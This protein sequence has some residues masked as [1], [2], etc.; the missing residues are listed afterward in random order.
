M[1]ISLASL[2]SGRDTRPPRVLVHGVSG[3]GKTTLA[4]AADKPVFLQTE[5]GLGVLDAQTFGLLK[6]FDQVMEGLGSLYTEDHDFK[7]LVVDSVDWLEP[8]VWAKVC[9][10][11]NWSSIEQPGYGKGYIEAVNVWREYIEGLNA[12]RDDKGMT[13]VQIAHTE[14]KRFENP[15]TEPYDRYIIKLHKQAAALLME[16][17]DCVLFANYRVSTVQSKDKK[18]TRAVGGGDRVLYTTE[19]PAFL[20]KNRYS[21]PDTLPLDWSELSQHIPALTTQQKEAA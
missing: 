4:A 5:D 19:R 15:E 12:L 3:V 17:S 14:V 16:H 13:I 7:T 2:K 20:A 6:T 18:T 21:L 10:A 8:L 1:A 9:S 11:N